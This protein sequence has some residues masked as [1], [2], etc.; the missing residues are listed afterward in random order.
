[1]KAITIKQPWATMIVIGEKR[2]E[3]RGWLTLSSF[4]SRSWQRE[5]K[6]CGIRWMAAV[7]DILM[8]WLRMAHGSSV[9]QGRRSGF[10]LGRVPESKM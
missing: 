3:T 10:L 8:P 7:S 4:R 2:F 6:V 1:M 9:G 5:S